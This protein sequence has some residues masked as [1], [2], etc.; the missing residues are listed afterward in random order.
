MLQPAVLLLDEPLSNLDAALRQQMREL[1]KSIQAQI[2]MTMLFVTH[3]QTEALTLSHRVSVLLDGRLRQIGAPQ[4]VFYEPVD[5]EVAR[6]FG[7]CNFF[8]G[9]FENGRFHSDIGAFELTQLPG[10]NG[11]ALTATIRPE[12][13]VI[14][15]QRGQGIEAIVQGVSFEGSAT[16]LRVEIQ[17]QSWCVL[18]NSPGFS[19]GQPVCL[20]FP[21]E[22]I[23]IFT[24][25]SST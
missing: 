17:G 11:H 7:G 12:D 16:R 13:I 19:I 3:D 20:R 15:E 1:I 9:R 5:T 18:S 23:R 4:Q 10:V 8:S 21:P 24:G 14:A 2:R 6:F 22:K 25:G